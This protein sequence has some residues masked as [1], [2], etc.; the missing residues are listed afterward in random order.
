MNDL[1]FIG[2][3][4]MFDIKTSDD[5]V[6]SIRLSG[7][8]THEDYK[9]HLIPKLESVIEQ[10]KKVC[11]LVETDDFHGWE[12]RAAFDD[13]ETGIKHRKEFDRIAIVGDKKWQENLCKLFSLM[14]VAE[15][16]YFQN[17]ELD[18]A[19]QWVHHNN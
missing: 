1:N 8:L 18:T 4:S 12:W 6:L 3:I 9:N 13:F 10:H 19:K 2:E 15:V 14:M 16:Q 17:N 7:K 5:G 11:L